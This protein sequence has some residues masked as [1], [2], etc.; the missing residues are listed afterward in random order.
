MP[1]LLRQRFQVELQ[2]LLALSQIKDV[3]LEVEKKYRS[4]AFSVN[5]TR[6]V[7]D[8]NALKKRFR[9]NNWHKDF[10]MNGSN[11]EWV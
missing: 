5:G 10:R 9:P 2:N 3:L 8:Y 7:G 11:S 4:L 6:L 1:E